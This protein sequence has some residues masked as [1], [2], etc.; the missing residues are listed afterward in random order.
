MKTS[1]NNDCNSDTI[2][3]EI[4]PQ[5][6]L[7]PD[8]ANILLREI[9]NCGHILRIMI[10]GSNLPSVVN[11][12]PGKG[13]KINHPLKKSIKLFGQEVPIKNTIGRLYLEVENDIIASLI[14]DK[15]KEILKF[16]FEYY[17]GVFFKKH[18]TVVDY[19]KLGPNA[20]ERLLGLSDPKKDV[21][22]QINYI[23]ITNKNDDC[24]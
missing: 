3:I 7:G 21:Q 9:Y 17:K 16:P 22:E 23:N 4:V 24:N 18:A 14:Y 15:C 6:I 2:Q 8:T 5:R 1:K 11:S 12:G 10:Q 20:D 13:E 19:V